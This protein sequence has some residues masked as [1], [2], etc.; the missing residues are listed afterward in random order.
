EEEALNNIRGDELA[1]AQSLNSELKKARVSLIG[2][3]ND[4]KFKEY[5]N[6]RVLSCLSEEEI[7]FPPYRSPE[8]HDILKERTEE[9][10]QEGVLSPEVIPIIAGLA[11]R[12][13]GDARR[14]LDL[15]RV[16][17][18]I[19]E[20]TSVPKVTKSHVRDAQGAIE[21]NTVFECISTLPL[22]SKLVLFA[23]YKLAETNAGR[24]TTGAVYEQY[25]ESTKA[26]GVDPITQR[27]V[28]DLINELDTLGIVT[29]RVQSRGR[30]G[31]TKHLY[32]SVSTG[33][34]KGVF[35]TDR[36]LQSML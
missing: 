23:I 20:R 14:A 22:Q 36:H 10:F 24:I 4:L 27:R 13:H 12:E 2:I 32:L 31:R 26:V 29:A 16:A 5:L 19:A 35:E 28:S 7:V 17:G 11:A 6:A 21:R 30:Y 3:S 15:L 18:E 34:I 25:M 1:K 8:L 9:G 33:I